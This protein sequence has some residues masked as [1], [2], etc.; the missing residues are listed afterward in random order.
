MFHRGICISQQIFPLY[1]VCKCLLPLLALISYA[2]IKQLVNILLKLSR[3]NAVEKDKAGMWWEIIF[4]DVITCKVGESLKWRQGS[5]C[6]IIFQQFSHNIHVETCKRPQGSFSQLTCAWYGLEYVTRKHNLWKTFQQQPIEIEIHKPIINFDALNLFLNKTFDF[7][8]WNFWLRDDCFFF[9]PD[10]YEYFTRMFCRISF[11]LKWKPFCSLCEYDKRKER[12]H[13]EWNWK[14][15]IL[16]IH[17][18]RHVL[19]STT[20]WNWKELWTSRKPQL[21]HNRFWQIYEVIV[22]TNINSF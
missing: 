2:F 5:K 18:V 19:H 22:S 1:A 3:K 7:S 21:G 17:R 12:E 4:S 8:K 16:E 14:M 9:F 11:D 20:D 10:V 6:C 13:V 15:Q